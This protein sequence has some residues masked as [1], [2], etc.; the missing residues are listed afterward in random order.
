MI[1]LQFLISAALLIVAATKLAEFGD[2]IAIR[3][4][5]GRLF[6]GTILLSAAT[7]LPEFL[8]VIN[9]FEAGDV[10]LAAGNLF[11]SNMFNMFMLA[12]L[13]LT[14][15]SKRILRVIY[16]RHALSGTAASLMAG[17]VLV[18]IVA[19]IKTM[20]GWVGLDSILIMI[21]YIGIIY[22]LRVNSNDAG[23][24]DE[25]EPDESLPS[26][27]VGLFGFGLAAAL[28]V[29]VSPW[30]VESSLGIAERTGLSSG[31]IG[32][33]L[34]GI[35]T[36]LPELVTTIAAA[37]LGAFDLAAGNLFGSNMFNM[38]ALGAADLFY[39]DGRLLGQI[40]P[41]FLLAGLL[42]L[43]MTLFGVLGNTARLEKRF[44]LFE[45]DGLL[46]FVI[47][48]VG[49]YLVYIQ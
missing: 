48:F 36:S 3:T 26:L 42:G 23:I 1:W 16:S 6:I 43:V 12:V 5:L 45:I 13:D 21:G 18:F 2:V 40:D 9:S 32:T 24:V 39:T 41:V 27:W 11:G 35:T 33:T 8:T 19:N 34:V 47:Y 10:Y 46:L 17:L 15:Q 29:I 30:L 44:W 14:F 22:I 7:S 28:L 37:R 49:L 38:F 4:G 20:V 25:E 31:F